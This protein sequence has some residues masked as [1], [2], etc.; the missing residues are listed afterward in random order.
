MSVGGRT[1][2]SDSAISR[3]GMLIAGG[4]EEW[5]TGRLAENASVGGGGG[6]TRMSPAGVSDRE[7]GLT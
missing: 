7:A 3:T 4:I 1:G 5:T 6:L 2:R